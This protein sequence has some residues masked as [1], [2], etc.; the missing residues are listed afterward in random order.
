M[1]LYLSAKIKYEVLELIDPVDH[2]TKTYQLPQFY[3]DQVSA[4]DAIQKNEPIPNRDEGVS[5]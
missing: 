5:Q 1:R 3:S 4:M 2:K